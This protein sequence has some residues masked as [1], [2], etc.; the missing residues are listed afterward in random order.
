MNCI[1]FD[2]GNGEELGS[3][4]LSLWKDGGEEHFEIATAGMPLPEAIALVKRAAR[5]RINPAD[6]GTL[7]VAVTQ[8][9]NAV[10]G[11]F[12]LKHADPA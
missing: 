5:L 2:G 6:G 3:G 7:D 9:G 4:E 10:L 8:A 11:G 1:I 12:V